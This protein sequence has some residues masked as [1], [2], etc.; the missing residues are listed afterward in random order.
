MRRKADMKTSIIRDQGRWFAF[1]FVVPFLLGVMSCS[2]GK[3]EGN[4][5][6]LS[7]DDAVA[8]APAET[9][10]E[11]LGTPVAASD[12]S[13]KDMEGRKVSLSDYKGKVVWV[14]FWATWCHA[15]LM[16]LTYMKEIRDRLSER[17]FEMLAINVEASKR[18]SKAISKV[19]SMKASYPVL[20]DPENKVG[21]RYNPSQELP[22]AVLIDRQGRQ[23]F[24]QR[25]FTAGEHLEIEKL[26]R[27][28]MDE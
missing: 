6:R 12:F 15:C 22:F 2:A 3:I 8:S 20:F 27:S 9:H 25:G 17:G 21:S 16:E 14:S 26:I 4:P 10:T 28:V 1:L 23:R 5:D 24:I 7:S 13:L 18:R 19:R 11:T